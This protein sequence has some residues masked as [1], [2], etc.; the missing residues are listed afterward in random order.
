MNKEHLYSHPE[1]HLERVNHLRDRYYEVF[2]DRYQ[3]PIFSRMVNK[4]G[5]HLMWSVL[6]HIAHQLFELQRKKIWMVVVGPPGSGKTM[7]VTE[8]QK[9]ILSDSQN[10]FVNSLL[11]RYFQDYRRIMGQPVPV[12]TPPFELETNFVWFDKA[13][14]FANKFSPDLAAN[15]KYWFEETKWVKANNHLLFQHQSI[16]EQKSDNIQFNIAEIV[17]IGPKEKDR[18]RSYL[19]YIVQAGYDPFVVGAIGSPELYQFTER[20]RD[21]VMTW[22]DKIRLRTIEKH[23]I[24]LEGFGDTTQDDQDIK[25][26]VSRM[27]PPARVKVIKDEGRDYGAEKYHSATAVE[28]AEILDLFPILGQPEYVQDTQQFLLLFGMGWFLYK[29]V[30]LPPDRCEIGL[31]SLQKLDRGKALAY[32]MRSLIPSP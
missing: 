27:C 20:L 16:D 14:Y 4:N 8:L 18:G 11:F 15:I 23:G 24:N 13:F 21:D 17:G 26:A 9:L 6:E 29:S 3:I 32:N 12:S 25:Y 1:N 28:K 10:N 7:K 19:N 22:P 2:I 5:D 30:K 31:N